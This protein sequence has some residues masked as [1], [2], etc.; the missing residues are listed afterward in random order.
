MDATA[1][2][3][4][5]AHVVGLGAGGDVIALPKRAV[6][7]AFASVADVGDPVQAGAHGL[8]EARARLAQKIF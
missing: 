1:T 5:N 4:E 6:A 2:V 8:A 7:L 3:D